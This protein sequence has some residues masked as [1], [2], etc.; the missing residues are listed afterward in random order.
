M[1]SHKHS[2][3]FDV[4]NLLLLGQGTIFNFSAAK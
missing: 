3:H 1:N 2:A 4:Q